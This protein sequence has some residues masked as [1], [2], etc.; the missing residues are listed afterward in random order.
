MNNVVA[1]I[2]ICVVSIACPH[3]ALAAPRYELIDFSNRAETIVAIDI[4]D[5]GQ[6]A[7]SLKGQTFV[8]SPSVPNGGNGNLQLVPIGFQNGVKGINNSGQIVADYGLTLG[9]FVWTPTANDTAI[10]V[11]SPLP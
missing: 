9:A 3:N 10:G 7:A 8:W 5:A 1:T 6:I 2:L 11:L 4:N